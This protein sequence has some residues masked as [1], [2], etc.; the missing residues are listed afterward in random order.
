MCQPGQVVDTQDSGNVLIVRYPSNN[1]LLTLHAATVTKVTHT[2]NDRVMVV[3]SKE[4]VYK[5]RG[6][7]ATR[8]SCTL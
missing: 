7:N 5:Y 2:K 3:K 6:M 8:V 1:A 4:L